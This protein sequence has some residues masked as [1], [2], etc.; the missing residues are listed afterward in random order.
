M[1]A[2]YP[3]GCGALV[4]VGR[5]HRFIAA[6]PI[7]TR[8]PPRFRHCR[9]LVVDALQ[10]FSASPF[11]RGTGSSIN[12]LPMPSPFPCPS[13]PR[14][15][16]A[17]QPFRGAASSST[18]LSPFLNDTPRPCLLTFIFRSDPHSIVLPLA[19]TPYD[20]ILTPFSLLTIL[21]LHNH[22]IRKCQ[23]PA[24]PSCHLSSRA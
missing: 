14:V 13:L 9:R 6:L 16:E 7:A 18:R 10:R 19:N 24:C 3:L 1:S 15:S 2:L 11:L 12:S 20:N 5:A 17:S 22:L 23:Q 21:V 8:V 4:K